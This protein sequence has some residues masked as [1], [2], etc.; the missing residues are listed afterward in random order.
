MTNYHSR[1]I[2]NLAGVA[3]P[4]TSLIRKSSIFEWRQPCDSAMTYIKQRLFE[5]PVVRHLDWGKP[6]II[7]PSA[8][9]FIVVAVLLQNDLAGRAHLVYFASRLLNVC[10][11]KYPSTEKLTIALLFSSPRSVVVKSP[12][13]GL[14]QVM[15][16]TH[17]TGRT[18]KFLSILQQYD[19]VLKIAKDSDRTTRKSSSS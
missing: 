15:L 12:Q 5:D 17:P 13:E 8:S 16:Q 14:K 3:K 4:I 1:L 6:F 18:A 9:E 10:K 19:L 2:E 11:Q 7:N